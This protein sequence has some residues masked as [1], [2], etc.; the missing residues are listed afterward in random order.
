MKRIGIIGAGNFGLALAEAL[1]EKKADVLLMD[2]SMENV[3][4]AMQWVARAVEGD[5]TNLRALQDAGF[6]SCDVVV[7]A[8]GESLEGGILATVNCKEL[9]IGT[10][11][12]KAVTD[13][14]GRVLKRVGADM[15]V[16]PE[17]SHARH[18]AQ[19]LVRGNALENYELGEGVSVTEMVPPKM[20]VGKKVGELQVRRDFGVRL[21][22]I[23]RLQETPTLPRILIVAED[24]EVVQEDDRVLVFGRDAEIERFK[25]G[26]AGKPA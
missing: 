7:V 20:I 15:I 21:L 22:A 8:T 23:R 4:E 9:G 19:T 10:V 25:T 3:K 6:A 1:F 17:R 24:E 11:V 16:F 14:Q 5:A 26:V 18:L 12:A 13:V 2:A